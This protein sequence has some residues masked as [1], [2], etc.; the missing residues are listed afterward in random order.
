MR[1]RRLRGRAVAAACLAVAV[2]VSAAPAIARP[3]G[4]GL[5][6]S[7]AG[8]V[9]ANPDAAKQGGCRL[10][11]PADDFDQAMR[12]PSAMAMAP[13]G[14]SLY[15]TGSYT[16][17]V[18]NYGRKAASGALSFVDC[19]TGNF[20]GP[21]TELATVKTT[22]GSGLNLVN[23]VAVSH[24]GRFVYTT[25]GVNG[26]DSTVMVFARD[27]LSGSLSFRSCVTGSTEMNNDNPGVCTMLPGAPPNPTMSSPALDDPVGIV[28]SPNDRFVYVSQDFAISTFQRDPGSG[29]LSFEG[30]LTA[31]SGDSPPCIRTRKDVI[32]DPRSSLIAPDGR[33]LYLATQHGGSV[34]TF[35]LNSANG[36]IAFRNCITE[37]KRLQPACTLARTAGRHSY[38]GL[39]APTGLA[40]S[41]DG[42]SLYVTSMFGSLELFKRNRGTGDLTATGCI[43]ATRESP[44]CTIIPAARRLADGTGL[45]GARGVVVSRN[46]RRLYVA[47]GADSSLAA[48][49]RNPANGNLSYLGCMTADA[50]FGPDG[51]G[52][53]SKVLKTGS[54]RGYGSGLYKV[55]QLL[56]SPDGR[57]LYGLDVGDDAISRFRVG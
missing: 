46:G 47:A 2:A 51:N 56:L 54:R 44:T 7:F 53:C 12:R 42:R 18:V 45:S 43:A 50:K 22:T 24:D 8:C 4:N 28:I 6:V 11:P 31:L 26:G 40:L 30:C 48:F 38:G 9:T 29:A 39:D 10:A 17:S 5:G 27:P 34:V 14:A 15:A 52:A 49:K 19:L 57:W 37:N 23:A 35:D 33:S 1:H 20:G 21:C 13:D 32:D 16:S 55:S 36:K 3:A 41:P 25:S